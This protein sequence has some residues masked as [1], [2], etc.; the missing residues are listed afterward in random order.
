MLSTSYYLIFFF[1]DKS[2]ANT[3]LRRESFN[4]FK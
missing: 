3:E 1:L 2:Y 4:S